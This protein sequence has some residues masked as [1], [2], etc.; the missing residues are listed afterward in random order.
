MTEPTKTLS[1]DAIVKTL[2]DGA[3]GMDWELQ[4]TLPDGTKATIPYR[5]QVLRVDENID[6]L[7]SAQSFAKGKDL[8]GY[9][10]VYRESQ[11]HELLVRAIRHREKR[12]RS[13][14]T[15]YYPPVF[16]ETSQLR[17]SL[18]EMDMAALLN[19]YEITKSFFGVVD[20][21]EEH[22]AEEWIARLS[23]PLRGPF[24]LSQLDSQHW[25]GL[26]LLLAQIAR[27]LYQELGRELPSLEPSSA[28]DSE[29]STSSTTSSGEPPV[30]SA[31][32]S[33]LPDVT[34]ERQLSRDEAAAL[35]KKRKNEA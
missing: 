6:A 28:S 11:A 12:D 16:V 33:D 5:M 19:A 18:N 20:G 3:P 14:N 30:A 29:S 13:D 2:L 8:E 7:Q 23:D 34:G 21:I 17:Q 27:D 15:S 4:K 1:P 10:D 22:S 35:V 32:G 25:P 31:T 26:I 9:G 24:R